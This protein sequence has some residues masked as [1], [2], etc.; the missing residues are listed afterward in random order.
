[1]FAMMLSTAL[2]LSCCAAAPAPAPAD[3]PL[4]DVIGVTHSTQTYHLTDKDYL[5][6]GA[7]QVLEFG[8]RVIKLWAIY[9]ERCYPSKTEWPK[10]TSL[11][12][13]MQT[14]DFSAVLA[15][16][17]KT[18]ILV[19][20]SLGRFEHYWRDGCPAEL[21]QDEER[22]FHDLSAWLMKTYRG[23]GK[24][25]VLQHWEGDWAIRTSY[26][27]TTDPPEI[28]FKGMI[29]WLNARQ[30]GVNRARAENPD[31]DVRVF[32]AA[33]VNLVAQSMLQG[34]P[35]VVNRVLPNTKLDLVSY[36]SWDTLRDRTLFR[37]ALDFI[38]ENMPDS[39]A[40]GAKNVYLGEYGLP[41]NEVKPEEFQE[42][43]RGTTETA[44]EWG[45]TYVVYWS[46]YCNEA[47]KTPVQTTQDN[48]GVWLI[49]PDGSRSWAYGYLRSR[50]GY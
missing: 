30:S 7:D 26:D 20:Y 50:M 31:S 39:A 46:L 24:T 36:S 5:N 49:R 10:Y 8:S 23:S 38:A 11:V 28:A 43:I 18:Y 9:P 25:F 42:T 21:A 48:R 32:H 35:G 40:F 22:Q 17:F 47:R 6:E 3:M 19:V 14:P 45:C 41:E 44:L 16:P 1:M 13:I 33:E 12:G 27:P 37:K 29:D 34:R 15:K 2:C 4:R